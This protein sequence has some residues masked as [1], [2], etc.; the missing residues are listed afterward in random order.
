MGPEEPVAEPEPVAETTPEPQPEPVAESEPAPKP[1]PA[2]EPVAETTPEPT[3]APEAEEAPEPVAEAEAPESEEAEAEQSLGEMNANEPTPAEDQGGVVREG[4]YDK[5][6]TLGPALDGV[7]TLLLI[8]SSEVGQRARA[9][10]ER[11]F[12]VRIYLDLLVKVDPR[13][14]TR[15]RALSE[16]GL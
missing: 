11:F 15:E 8:S 2:P 16:L 10:L 6:E 3:P 7:D 9:E 13:W 5:P 14:F 12:G 4:N 1:T